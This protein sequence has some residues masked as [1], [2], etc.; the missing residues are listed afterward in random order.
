MLGGITSTRLMRLL[1]MLC[2]RMNRVARR[3]VSMFKVTF[4]FAW[5]GMQLSPGFMIAESA[6]LS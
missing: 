4:M 6:L 5:Y 2:L 1:F 3:A